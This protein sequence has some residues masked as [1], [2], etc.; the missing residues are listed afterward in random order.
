MPPFGDNILETW[1][2]GTPLLVTANYTDRSTLAWNYIKVNTASG[3]TV[4]GETGNDKIE[5]NSGND[6]LQ[7]GVGNDYLIGGLGADA[8]SGGDN[9][10][11]LYGGLG[12]DNISGGAG[13]DIVLI[14]SLDE[15]V[16]APRISA[17]LASSTPRA[18]RAAMVA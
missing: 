4:K 2:N 14:A 18:T 15:L 17:E 3:V 11:V 5:G 9:N 13:N 12:A 10:D 1:K 16:S 8:L 6:N 7:G